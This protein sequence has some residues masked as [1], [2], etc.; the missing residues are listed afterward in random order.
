M[1]MGAGRVD[2]TDP[3]VVTPDGRLP[4][5]DLGKPGVDSADA[6]GLRATFYRMGFNDQEIVALSGAHAL[7]RCHADFSGC[8]PAPSLLSQPL[9][10]VSGIFP[11]GGRD[12]PPCRECSP[13]ADVIGPHVGNI[14]PRRTRL[15]PVSGIFP[16]GGRDW[17]PCREY[18]A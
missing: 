5:A 16:L 6:D 7:G 2:A 17:P 11:L 18:F 15:A 3:S 9:A 8:E 14:P 4:A 12:W 13:S 10:P 1:A